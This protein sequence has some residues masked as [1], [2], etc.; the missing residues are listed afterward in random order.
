MKLRSV[1]RAM[2]AV[3]LFGIWSA[4]QATPTLSFSYD[5]GVALTCADGALCDFNPD[6]GAV[7]FF[8]SIGDFSLNVTT[9]LAKPF[10][11]HPQLMDLFSLD[12]L[13][14]GSTAHTLSIMFT[15]TG[16]TDV[17]WINGAFGGTLSGPVGSTV[18]ARGYSDATNTLFGTG[19]A[20]GS[21][22][23]FGAPGGFGTSSYAQG[24][25]GPYSLT[26]EIYI[27]MAGAGSFS[28]DYELTIPE[29]S[30][31]ALTGVA[32]LALGVA[33]RRRQ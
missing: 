25:G 31:L 11:V 17:G 22:G 10:S 23:A 8:G 30:A 16:F 33:G 14:A 26:Q 3:A 21:I 19:T 18:T 7:S 6:V 5:G 1:V 32:L 15:E 27:S 13:K 2:S 4:A 9:G 29:P 12:V 20:L 24:A 28:G